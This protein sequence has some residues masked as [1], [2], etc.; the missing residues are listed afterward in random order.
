MS[1]LNI[2]TFPNMKWRWVDLAEI[3]TVLNLAQHDVLIRWWNLNFAAEEMEMIFTQGDRVQQWPVQHISRM[4]DQGTS[5]YVPLGWWNS[6][7]SAR[8]S[9]YDGCIA[10][11]EYELEEAGESDPY[12]N[13]LRAF[14]DEY[15]GG[16]DT[17]YIVIGTKDWEQEVRAT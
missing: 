3:S 2:R 7:K 12:Q 8:E 11:D 17:R 13:Q 1:E 15:C 14:W 10:I 9:G 4:I 16:S 5:I 6:I